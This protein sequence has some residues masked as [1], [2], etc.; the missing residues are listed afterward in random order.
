MQEKYDIAINHRIEFDRNFR[1]THV[2]KS[3]NRIFDCWNFSSGNYSDQDKKRADK[4]YK[5]I[6]RENKDYQ[7]ELRKKNQISRDLGDAKQSLNQYVHQFVN[8]KKLE[9]LSKIIQK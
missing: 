2:V 1:E 5:R 8:Q 6:K 9:Y 4:E 3:K 7:T